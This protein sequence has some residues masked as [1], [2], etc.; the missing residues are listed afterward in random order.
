MPIAP[1]TTTTAAA[2]TALDLENGVVAQSKVTGAVIT[3]P[4]AS[5]SHHFAQVTVETATGSAKPRALATPGPSTARPELIIAVG[6][7]AMSTNF[8]MLSGDANLS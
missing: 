1:A 6:A 8:A 4:V 3:I 5:M 7:K 2:S